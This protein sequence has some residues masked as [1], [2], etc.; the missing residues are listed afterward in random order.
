MFLLR[1]AFT[2]VAACG[3]LLAT[4]P[5]DAQQKAPETGQSET[6]QSK[7]G[8][9]KPDDRAQSF[10]GTMT[11]E[12]MGRIISRLD[13]GAKQIRAGYWQF[14]I[15]RTPVVIVTD[16]NAGRMRIMVPVART[17]DL[18][19]EDLLRIA[20]A[21]FDSALD[22]RYAVAQ[23]ILWSVFIHPLHELHKNQ[24]ITAI[25]QTVNLALTYGTTY[26]SGALT[27]GGGD[28]RDIIRRKLID[29][30]LKKGQEI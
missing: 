4:G 18:T 26:T 24:F 10:E 14:A 12:I 27:F 3:L 25:G 28:S 21:N 20:Q 7:P 29:D 30:L 9:S 19:S 13:K 1:T 5:A 2:I 22:S 11:L 6:G 16:K 15:E 17:S 8:Q 23:K